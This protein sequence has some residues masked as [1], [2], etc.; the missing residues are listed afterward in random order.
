MLELVSEVLGRGASSLSGHSV[1]TLRMKW[2]SNFVHR[3]GI[4]LKK[5][6]FSTQVIDCKQESSNSK[7]LNQFQN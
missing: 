2:T 3:T 6:D 1:N 4:L 5:L 7:Y